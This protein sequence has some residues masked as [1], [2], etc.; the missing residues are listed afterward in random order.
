MLAE[1]VEIIFTYGF[2][3]QSALRT[4]AVFNARHP[5]KSI[6]HTYAKKL[7]TKFEETGS[8]ANKK[9]VGPR[10]LDEVAQIEI[11]G[12]FTATPTSSVRKAKTV[13]GISRETVRR[14]L[15]LHKFY[16][17][18]MQIF[19]ELAEDDYDQDDGENSK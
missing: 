18:K 10:V 1:R 9:R 4:T 17:Y 15:K 3:G 12:H 5:E 16:P 19:Q 2:E 14:A 8:V 6:S 7:G 13:T 11:L